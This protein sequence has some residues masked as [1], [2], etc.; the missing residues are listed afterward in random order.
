M[1]R[2]TMTVFL[3]ILDFSN[4]EGESSVGE[5][6]SSGWWEYLET[7]GSLSIDGWWKNDSLPYKRHVRVRGMSRHCEYQGYIIDKCYA[8]VTH[9]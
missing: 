5:G 8:L 9:W 2:S 4:G 7:N 1:L 6:G 3:G